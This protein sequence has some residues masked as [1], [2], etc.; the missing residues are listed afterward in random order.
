MP[1]H[2]ISDST[3]SLLPYGTNND[4]S[5]LFLTLEKLGEN[6]SKISSR[7]QESSNIPCQADFRRHAHSGWPRDTQR[8][9]Y[10]LW[11]V[12]SSVISRRTSVPWISRRWWN[13]RNFIRETNEQTSYN[14][15]LSSLTAVSIYNFRIFQICTII[16]SRIVPGRKV[17]RSFRI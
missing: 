6:F 17:S 3:S 9:L 2:V 15:I 14:S 7:S 4:L 8:L 1:I 5:F 10:P 13:F 11:R 16:K 12:R